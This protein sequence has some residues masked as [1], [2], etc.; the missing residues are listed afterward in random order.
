MSIATSAGDAVYGLGKVMA[1]ARATFTEGVIA[2]HILVMT[3]TSALSLFAVF[4]VDILTL[5]Y[6]S[7]LHEPV[8]LAA[9]GIAKVLIFL[10]SA[11]ANGLI[12]AAATVLS[13]RIGHRATQAVSRFTSSLM[14]MVFVA[15][16][17]TAALQ[18]VMIFPI[19]H[20]LGADAATYE[21]A[22]V[23]IWL[24]LPFSVL[25]SVM[26]MSAQILRTAGDSRRALWA[27]LSG[28]ATLAVADPLLI[29]VLDLGIEGAG[30]AYALSAT[31]SV[32]L[33]VYWVRRHVG[34]AGS[35]KPRLLRMH[36]RRTFRI[37]LPAMVGNLATPVGLAYLVSSVAA[38]GTSAL[39]AMAVLDRVMQFAYCVF[40][41]LPS[42]L[43]PVLGQNIGAHLD[44]RVNSA[45]SFSRRLVVVY[46]LVIW[47]LLLL[48][49]STIANFYGL[50]G[51]GRALLLAFCQV[52]GGLWV[53]IGLD[54]VAISVFLTMG[55]P[56]WVALFAW[57]RSTVGTLPFVFVATHLFGSSGA[58]PGMFTGNALVALAS[59]M[60]ASFTARRFFTA[61]S[62][63]PASGLVE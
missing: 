62:R 14:L 40:F 9:V 27:V 57:L 23:F 49:C 56:W 52:G 16:G 31:V 43:A 6:V 26:Q 59:I 48:S 41:A 37:A 61:R 19:T 63:L 7:M 29:F 60:T 34:M 39:A 50:E 21:A 44:P 8:L 42:A 55:R 17:L 45:I 53:F 13:E 38:F 1:V 3:G 2:R 28:A 4:L 33:G 36:L 18:L 30:L 10:N 35:I 25:Q 54:F 22:R 24:T 5:V 46:G 15:S 12:I 11:V 20:L 58:M 47:G 51:E 32:C